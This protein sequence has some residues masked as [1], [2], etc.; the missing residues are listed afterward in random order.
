MY[1]YA[2]ES[3]ATHSATR[4]Y[5]W[6]FIPCNPASLSLPKP[7]DL[8]HH[9]MLTYLQCSQS[10]A[11][12]QPT[13]RHGL[14]CPPIRFFIFGDKPPSLPFSPP[15]C[16]P[17]SR[18]DVVAA[19]RRGR[20]ERYIALGGWAGAVYVRDGG[21]GAMRV[22]R[23]SHTI[24]AGTSATQHVIMRRTRT[25]C[26]ARRLCEPSLGTRAGTLDKTCGARTSDGDR[27][28]FL[29]SL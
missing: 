6:C 9:A 10:I 4:V 23:T 25:M 26:T 8:H 2:P 19:S 18:F 11:S 13:R 27:S 22:V 28:K 12:G 24:R 3:A 5:C 15:A 20:D 7:P 21:G 1:A 16:S 14:R 17:L 29:L